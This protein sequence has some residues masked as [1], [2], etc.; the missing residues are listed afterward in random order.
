[1]MVDHKTLKHLESLE[2][3]LDG[4]YHEIVELRAKVAALEV[5]LE[6]K[7]N[8]VL[9]RRISE[10]TLENS[11]L[12]AA[13]N[14]AFRNWQKSSDV[15]GAMQH[16]WETANNWPDDAHINNVAHNGECDAPIYQ[17]GSS[18]Y[19]VNPVGH[20]AIVWTGRKWMESQN[21]TNELVLKQGIIVEV[22]L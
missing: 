3:T 11:K 15:F 21:I 17:L 22:Q 14:N 16:L 5:Q 20:Y 12:K 19:R 6:K 9:A 8:D 4:A 1:M 2:K 13:A 18:Y 10:L 7:N